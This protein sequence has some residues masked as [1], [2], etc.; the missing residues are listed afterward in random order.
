MKFIQN[1]G[2]IFTITSI[3]NQSQKNIYIAKP[4]RQ[5]AHLNQ[6]KTDRMKTS[7]LILLFATCAL[8][9]LLLQTT[10]AADNSGELL[11]SSSSSSPSRN[12]GLSLKTLYIKTDDNYRTE[13]SHKLMLR[14]KY[15]NYLKIRELRSEFCLGTKVI[16]AVTTDDTYF[17]N[18]KRAVW[19][20][21]PELEWT[22]HALSN[23]LSH[24]YFIHFAAYTLPPDLT[25]GSEEAVKSLFCDKESISIN[26]TD[27]IEDGN[28]N[29]NHED[30]STSAK[31]RKRH[32][33][34]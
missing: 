17:F 7:L 3:S 20:A 15:H 9:P 24:V 5:H 1:T 16:L 21:R 28:N 23:D 2:S 11:S 12:N 4:I 25:D 6:P 31:T 14:G 19:P 8:V 26:F 30:F 33:Q 32:R 13:L 27:D 34:F 10:R 18:P 22:M 29:N